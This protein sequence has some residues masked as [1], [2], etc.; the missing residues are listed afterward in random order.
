MNSR[1][2]PMTEGWTSHTSSSKSTISCG[3]QLSS[4]ASTASSR[5]WCA[6]FFLSFAFAAAVSPAESS[7]SSSP[8]IAVA[9][10]GAR[11]VSVLG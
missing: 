1:A 7:T 6:G 3:S 11:C 9:S 2:P 5:G 8:L 10:S 4:S